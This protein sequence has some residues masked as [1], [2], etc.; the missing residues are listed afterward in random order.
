[1]LTRGKVAIFCYDS[2]LH[3]LNALGLEERQA[4]HLTVR[5]A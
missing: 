5:L 3:H 4:G 2:L 1:M